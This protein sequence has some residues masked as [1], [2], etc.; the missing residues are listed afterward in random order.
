M[1]SEGVCPECCYPLTGITEPR[2]PECGTALDPL[3]L[4]NPDLAIPR[5]AW[6]R[7]P[8]VTRRYAV[9]HTLWEIT[10]RP[11]R[12]FSRLQYDDRLLRAIRWPLYILISGWS[13]Y[14]CVLCVLATLNWPAQSS[15]QMLIVHLWDAASLTVGQL[16]FLI[17]QLGFPLMLLLI[18]GDLIM[19]RDRARFRLFAKLVL[20]SLTAYVGFAVALVS[21]ALVAE[22]YVGFIFHPW[23]NWLIAAAMTWQFGLLMA[24]INKKRFA[25]LLPIKPILQRVLQA[26]VIAS[27]CFAIY[28]ALY[29]RLFGWRFVTGQWGINFWGS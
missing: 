13:L 7:R 25:R 5:I 20:Y 17:A 28:L 11:R 23:P 2:C 29:D 1:S 4:Q 26:I 24:A 18:A 8:R 14:F 6:E 12:F 10:W 22:F 9:A 16:R 21:I 3:L 15:V 27:W 19:W